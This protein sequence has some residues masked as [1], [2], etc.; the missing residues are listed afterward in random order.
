MYYFEK[1]VENGILPKYKV[2][3]PND[4]MD[5]KPTVKLFEF[6]YEALD[7][8]HEEV[9]RRVD[10]TVQHSSDAVSEEELKQI[11]EYEYYLV[12][13]EEIQSCNVNFYAYKGV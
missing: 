9:Q 1:D 8:S 10:F 11:E 7:W 2:T 12:R 5:L 6:E 13:I 3:Y 4:E